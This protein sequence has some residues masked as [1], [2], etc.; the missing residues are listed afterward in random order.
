ME[1][2]KVGNSHSNPKHVDR[3]SITIHNLVEL[4]LFNA[5]RK[6]M[7]MLRSLRCQVNRTDSFEAD[8]TDLT[9]LTSPT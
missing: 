9:K 4:T 3:V 6:L 5:N 7:S 1:Q 2:R 8:V